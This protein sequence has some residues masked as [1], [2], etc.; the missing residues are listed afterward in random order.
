MLTELSAGLPDE[1]RAAFVASSCDEAAVLRQRLERDLADVDPSALDQGHLVLPVVVR[2]VE[3]PVET[4]FVALREDRGPS[5]TTVES[6]A[7]T[8]SEPVA[9]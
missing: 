3:V 2:N 1:E 5:R 7:L 6:V 8:A 9:Y 4:A